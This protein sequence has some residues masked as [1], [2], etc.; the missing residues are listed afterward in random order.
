MAVALFL[1]VALAGTGC[2]NPLKEEKKKELVRVLANDLFEEMGKYVLFWDGMDKGG[3]PV[4][5]G[6]YIIVFEIRDFQEQDFVM[7][8]AGKAK[9]EIDES[10]YEFGFY[11]NHEL[12]Q[13]YPNP[14]KILSG[15]NIP[16]IVAEVPAAVKLSVYKD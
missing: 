16:I 14:F 9:E 2:K 4:S 15:V 13:P 11:H 10:H 12:G 1:I 6:K 5:P 7:A 3:T 8:E